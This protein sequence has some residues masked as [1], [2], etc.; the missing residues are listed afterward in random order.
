MT[1]P[2]EV[3]YRAFRRGM[4]ENVW[5]RQE[6][7]RTEMKLQETVCQLTRSNAE[8]ERFT[9][10]VSHD[11]QEPLRMVASYVQLLA[12][13]YQGKLDADADEF[14]GFA[15]D[16][17]NRMKAM[18]DGLLEYSRIGRDG[19]DL[20]PTRAQDALNQSLA[21]LQTAIQ[22]SGA[23]ILWDPLP[24]VKSNALL[25]TE[26]FQNLVG[27][28]IKFRGEEPLRVRIAAQQKGSEWIFSVG[29]NGMGI[30]PKHAERIF[31]I[32]QRLHARDQYP[33]TG[34]G[35]AICK[36]IVERHGGRIWVESRPHEGATFH[37]T[38]PVIEG[39]YGNH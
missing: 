29:D 17:A 39:G 3:I 20:V 19:K 1:S 33:G 23:S 21:N 35:L 31:D 2:W 22:E 28:A 30:D 12:R 16:G 6:R 15:V 38:L 10:V 36:K 14:I 7:K 24:T 11:L 8:L 13:R 5:A 34:M 9:Y 26:L 18:I 32:F 37:F 25:F 27:N 4:V